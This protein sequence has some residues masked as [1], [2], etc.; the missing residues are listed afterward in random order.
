MR[1]LRKRLDRGTPVVNATDL[2]VTRANFGKTSSAALAA[3]DFNRDGVVNALDVAIVRK[4]QHKALAVFTAPLVTAASGVAASFNGM[5]SRTA[6]A[7]RRGVLGESGSDLM[8]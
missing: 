5:S 7:T 8:I 6:A 3:S 2:A 4:S 1:V